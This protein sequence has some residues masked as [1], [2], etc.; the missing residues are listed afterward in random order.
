M[1]APRSHGSRTC[2]VSEKGLR[3]RQVGLEVGYNTREFQSFRVAIATGRN[4]DSDFRLGRAAAGYKLTDELSAEYQLER[5]SLH[6]D[7]EGQGTWIH[8]LRASQF[9]TKDLFPR[10]F[11]QTNSAIDRRNLQAV[12]M[13]RYRPPF[14]ALQLAFQRGT[15]AFGERSQQGNTLLVKVTIVL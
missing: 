8:V 7:P 1:E 4:F 11:Y 10:V 15:A 13:W 6:P 3:N 12:F 5:L 9:F 2:S 14:G